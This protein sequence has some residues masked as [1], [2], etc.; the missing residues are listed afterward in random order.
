L[1]AKKLGVKNLILIS[2]DK[3]VR[4]TNI[5]GAS[6][7][8]AELICQAHAQKAS[9]T[10]FSMVR[11]GNVLGSSG[12]VIP[13]FRAQIESGGPVTVTH[14]D[15][16]RYFMTI[17]EAAQLVIQAGAI[18][19]GGDVFV[20][21]M[22]EP[23]KIL[24]VAIGMVKLHGLTPYFVDHPEQIFPTQ[25]DIPICITGLRKGEK[26]YEELLIGNNPSQ[27]QHP[28]IM[29]ASETFLPMEDLMPILDRLLQACVEFNL[30]SIIA[31]LHELPLEYAPM[32]DE[33]SDLIWTSEAAQEECDD[34]VIKHSA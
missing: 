1:A 24:D 34:M 7:R 11:F 18:G 6:K 25:G 3:A 29:T 2:T 30:P 32:S 12:S 33:I 28:Q 10:V 14:K 17:S 27:T 8:I 31:I 5:M 19:Q 26:L 20:L 21:D 15:I 22:G 4:P 16:T 23:V 9:A 13:R